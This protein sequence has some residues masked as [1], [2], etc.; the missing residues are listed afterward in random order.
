MERLVQELQSS[1][2][3]EQ[4]FL[5]WEMTAVNDQLASLLKLTPTFRAMLKVSTFD[6]DS[7]VQVTHCSGFV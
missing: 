5:L 6:F 1:P 3:T 4:H 7:I 2:I